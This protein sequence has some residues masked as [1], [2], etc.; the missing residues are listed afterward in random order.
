MVMAD[1]SVRFV[2]DSIDL[3]LAGDGHP[4]GRAVVSGP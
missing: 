1:G 2:S 3:H 4:D